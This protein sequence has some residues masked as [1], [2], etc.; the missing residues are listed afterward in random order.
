MRKVTKV[1][2]AFDDKE[3][4]TSGLTTD[5]NQYLNRDHVVTISVNDTELVVITSIGVE[6]NVSGSQSELAELRE[7]LVGNVQSNFVQI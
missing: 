1:A 5:R 4:G 6:I 3:A 7:D 2:R